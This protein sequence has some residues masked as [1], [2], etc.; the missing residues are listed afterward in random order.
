MGISIRTSY[1]SFRGLRENNGYYVDKTEILEEYLVRKFEKAVM[2]TRPRRFGKT[3]TMTMFRDFLDIRQD[4]RAIFD[5]LKIMDYPDTVDRYM[6]KYPVIFI[7][8]KEVYGTSLEDITDTLSSIVADVCKEY[9]YL[10]GSSK[11]NA[12]DRALLEELSQENGKAANV[13]SALK[14]LARMLHAYYDKDVFIIVDEYDVPMAKAQGRPYYDDVRNMIEKMLSY[15]CKTND[16]VKA[17]M[18][19]GCLYTVKN[20][21]YTGVNNITPYNILDPIYAPYIGFTDDDIR[22]ILDDAG[23]PEQYP[24]LEEWY[25]GYI[26][27]RT[28][29]YCPWDALS[30]IRAVLDGSYSEPMGPENYWVN[31]SQMSMSIVQGFLGKTRGINTQFEQLLAGKE[32]ECV[33]NE[34]I[35]YHTIYDNGDNIW[36]LLLET[37]YLT[38]GIY[39]KS[40]RMPLR[41]PN[42]EIQEVFRQEIWTYFKER[43]DNEYV[44]DL[45]NALWA[46]EAENAQSALCRILE[47]TVSFYHQ[48]QE[49]SYHLILS[50]FF[51][52]LGY[53][54]ISELETGYG[55]SDL[56]VLDMARKRCL[57]LELKHAK[58]EAGMI[59]ALNEATDQIIKQK[60]ESKLDYLGY[61]TRIKY[62]M[63]FCDK[64]ALLKRVITDCLSGNRSPDPS[65]SSCVSDTQ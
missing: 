31:S 5:G 65:L 19:S 15:V 24:V 46:G 12:V 14:M 49:Y 57:I 52:G 18:I 16:D 51:T 22:Q 3:L 62:G 42:R 28:R 33:I 53:R 43:L 13:T 41:I 55:R 38:K 56:V 7:S 59:S 58:E 34:H 8:L 36:S 50:G 48:Y 11:I 25:D 2:F 26:F 30:Y 39:E 37:G 17:V 10:S 32:I 60:Y 9:A 54:V 61:D 1:D 21:T 64:K 40:P 35:S 63:A 27:G 45:I 47:A 23:I 20:S 44:D 6:N 29:M 4:S